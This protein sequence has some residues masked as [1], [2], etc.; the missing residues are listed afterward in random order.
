[1]TGSAKGQI[2]L[3]F[4]SHINRGVRGSQLKLMGFT[5]RVRLN[6]AVPSLP[7]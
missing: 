5:D 4:Y 7:G 1:M 3:F 6:L 2:W